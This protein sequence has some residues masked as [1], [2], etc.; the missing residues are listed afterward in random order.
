MHGTQS[1]LKPSMEGSRIN[2]IR[3][4]KLL[5]VSKPLKIRM[6]NDIEDEFPWNFYESVYWVIDDLLLVQSQLSVSGYPL[7]GA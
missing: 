3:K 4:A 2:V 5:N 1:M 7:I 6:G